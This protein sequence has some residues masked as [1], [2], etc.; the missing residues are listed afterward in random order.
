LALRVVSVDS[1]AVT[2]V[3]KEQIDRI[4]ADIT[5]LSVISP[6]T[7]RKPLTN[8]QR[9]AGLITGIIPLPVDRSIMNVAIC[10]STLARV[11]P[12]EIPRAGILNP[13]YLTH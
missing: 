10:N 3:F 2:L 4:N 8:A 7:G 6:D 11:S 5:S 9:S 12:F 1:I 13:V